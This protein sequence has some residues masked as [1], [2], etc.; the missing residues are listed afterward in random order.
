VNSFVDGGGGAPNCPA[1]FDAAVGNGASPEAL[2]GADDA[3]DHV[4]LSGGSSGGYAALAPAVGNGG[5]PLMPNATPLPS[6]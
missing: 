2:I 3:G 4:N 1:L 6:P 5:C